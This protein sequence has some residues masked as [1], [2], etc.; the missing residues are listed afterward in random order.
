MLSHLL[1]SF[2][3]PRDARLA[4][5][6]AVIVCPSVCLSLCL[7]QAGIV[8]KR[9]NVE[10]RK[11]WHRDVCFLMLTVVGGR[12]PSPLNFAF[13]VTNL[14]SN[15]TISTGMPSRTIALTVS[16]ALL[17]FCFYIFLIF[18]ERELAFTIAICYQPS[19][20]CLSV[21]CRL[22]VCDVGAPYSGG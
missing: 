16:P 17:G 4:R 13:K 12:S 3:Y 1:M 15:T 7:S 8:S 11:Q 2:C 5:V 21:V 20:C 22:S 6:L 19:V 10:S 14:F 18:S 9:L